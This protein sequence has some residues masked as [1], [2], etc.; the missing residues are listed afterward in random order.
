MSLLPSIHSG[1]ASH[2]WLRLLEEQEEIARRLVWLLWTGQMR[3]MG[4]SRGEQLCLL[5]RAQ[6]EWVRCSE[7]MR[8]EWR[9][10]RSERL[11]GVVGRC[12]LV[13]VQHLNVSLTCIP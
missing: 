12:G 10:M 1:L 11:F 2:T 9:S 5:V 6:V 8:G 4:S 7:R 3:R 13:S